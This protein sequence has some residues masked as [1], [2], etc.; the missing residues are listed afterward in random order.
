MQSATSDRLQD[1]LDAISQNADPLIDVSDAIPALLLTQSHVV[2]RFNEFYTYPAALWRLTKRFNQEDYL[3][4]CD[5]CLAARQDLK[6]PLGK[7]PCTLCGAGWDE[8]CGMG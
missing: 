8:W 7:P 2:A 1:I 5:K 3:T 6:Y 4:A